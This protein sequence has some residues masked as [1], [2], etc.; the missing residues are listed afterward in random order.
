[1]IQSNSE[2]ASDFRLM[3]SDSNA[4][5]AACYRRRKAPCYRRTF[6][7][8]AWAVRPSCVANRAT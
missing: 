6:T 7:L 1:M 2:R 5:E 4:A 8:L 3:I